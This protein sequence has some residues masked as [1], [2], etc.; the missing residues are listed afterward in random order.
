M[1]IKRKMEEYQLE[2]FMEQHGDRLTPVYGHVLSVKVDRKKK[3]F[4]W[5]TLTVHLVVKPVGS[6]NVVRCQYKKNGFKEAP[7]IS[8]RQGN[9]VLVQGLK[10]EKGKEAAE[11]ITIMNVVNIT[12]RT[13]LVE[14]DMSVDEIIRSVKGN[15]KRQRV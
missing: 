10:G 14:G 1:G 8:L 5:N 12:D 7:F 15:I 6:R 11:S 9:E 13:Q 3:F 4:L 2:N